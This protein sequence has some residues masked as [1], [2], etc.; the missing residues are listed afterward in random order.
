MPLLL[1]IVPVVSTLLGG[2]VAIRFRRSLALLTAA[3]AGLLLGAALLDLMPEALALNQGLAA[4]AMNVPGL[5][6]L[7]FLFFMGVQT[8]LD[9]V[10]EYW[11]G[12][13]RVFGRLGGAL[14]IFHSLRDGMAIGLA[15]AA[16]HPAGYAVAVGIAAHDLGDGM[17]TV[18]STTGGRPARRSDHLFLLADAL[19]PLAG[20]L[21]TLWWTFSARSSVAMLAVAAGFFLQLATT[22]FLP[23]VRSSRATK[24]WLFPAVLGGAAII[25]MANWLMGVRP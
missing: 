2:L 25:Y 24:P 15:Y 3:G 1:L 18:I 14:L 6:L 4:G 17:N 13:G 22:D 7:S 19:A 10:A 21:L 11:A 23:G 5:M 9:A 8:A 20:G 16:S 12:S